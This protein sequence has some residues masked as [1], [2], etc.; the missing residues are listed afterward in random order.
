MKLLQQLFSLS[1]FRRS[2][3]K[4][5]GADANDGGGGSTGSKT[6]G[7]AGVAC[8]STI[9][10]QSAVVADV[11]NSDVVGSRVQDDV[12]DKP[13]ITTPSSPMRC[14][15][16]TAN[17]ICWGSPSARRS[18]TQRGHGGMAELPRSRSLIRTNPWLPPSSPPIDRRHL[19]R[20]RSP[21]PASGSGSASCPMTPTDSPAESVRR[22]RLVDTIGG[23]GT[24]PVASEGYCS[25]SSLCTMS[26]S[27]TLSTTACSDD[28]Q[29]SVD[30]LASLFPTLMSS[31]STSFHDDKTSGSGA[32]CESVIDS[33][34]VTSTTSI[35]DVDADS[36][37]T[38]YDGEVQY[39]NDFDVVATQSTKSVRSVD[40][41]TPTASATLTR[42]LSAVQSALD[43]GTTNEYD[44]DAD[45]FPFG[46]SKMPQR[47][48]VALPT[49]QHQKQRSDLD[50]MPSTVSPSRDVEEISSSLA[51]SVERLRRGRIAVDGAFGRALAEDSRRQRELVR[52]RRRMVEAQ[53]DVLL[54]TLRD[55][56]RELDGQCRRLQ[57]AY[58]VV[59]TSRWPR[60][61]ADT[62]YSSP[63]AALSLPS[64]CQSAI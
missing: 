35:V 52:L 6:I 39:K 7:I 63:T 22:W 53:R 1:L 49:Q 44:F 42:H 40:G 15:S 19:G 58:D 55:L 47:P 43:R 26:D 62:A 25:V 33:G 17:R 14:W 13:E 59:L 27:A 21:S 48:A 11:V 29:M 57:A 37:S 34:I 5:I 31:S 50:Q 28:L 51:A 60:L 4:V 24:T 10:H 30:S 41:E 16:P 36:V 61:H 3:S 32:F 45:V 56:R 46:G 12:C 23:E 8:D 18:A 64:L 9:S 54:G 20:G 38:A 2:R